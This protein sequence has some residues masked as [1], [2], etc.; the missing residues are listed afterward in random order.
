MNTMSP[1]ARIRLIQ[2]LLALCVAVF[3]AGIALGVYSIAQDDR[4][5]VANTPAAV[6]YVDIDSVTNATRGTSCAAIGGC[7]SLTGNYIAMVDAGGDPLVVGGKYVVVDIGNDITR[8]LPAG[9]IPVWT[10]AYGKFTL[11]TTYHT[12]GGS[13]ATTVGALAGFALLA[14]AVIGG[15][16]AFTELDYRLDI[17]ERRRRYA[18]AY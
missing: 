18:Y 11:A 1:I 2:G 12:I 17:E 9:E 6:G 3:F 16:I 14:L 10:D 13:T 5:R 4:Q 8:G 15:A 7:S